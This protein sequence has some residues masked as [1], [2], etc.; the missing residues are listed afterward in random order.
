MAL[1]VN[2]PVVPFWVCSWTIV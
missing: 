2:R 1:K